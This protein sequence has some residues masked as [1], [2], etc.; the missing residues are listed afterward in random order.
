VFCPNCGTQNDSAA[1]PCKKCGFKLSSVSLPK[2]RGTMM[3]NS[4]QTARELVDEHRRRQEGGADKDKNETARASEPAPKRSP[5]SSAPPSSLGGP[6]GPV[7]QP[8]RAAP[9]GR[10]GGTIMGVAP[11][12]GG[13]LPPAAGAR[14]PE[15]P[16]AGAG[17][18][19]SGDAAPTPAPAAPASEPTPSVEARPAEVLAASKVATNAAHPSDTDPLAGTVAVPVAGEG[20]PPSE[21]DSSMAAPAA[22]P[23]AVAVR[24][25]PAKTVPL[26]AVPSEAPAGDVGPVTA[27]N[28]APSSADR[29]AATQPPR[30]RAIPATTAIPQRPTRASD[31]PSSPP[32]RIRALDVVLIVCTLGLYG[33]VLLFKLRKRAA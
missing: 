23:P 13:I 20:T 31:A 12:S 24:A 21:S 14:P 15:T 5:G 8:P 11:Q 9:R 25:G 22:A 7:F 6:K 19:P 27:A 17:L 30:L 3:L 28:E 18:A 4:E 1:T 10:M 32:P 2:F 33:I 16:N 29:G 26:A